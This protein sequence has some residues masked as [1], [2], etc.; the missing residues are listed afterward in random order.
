MAEQESLIQYPT[1]FPIKVVG[2]N[3]EGFEAQIAQVL[4]N[5]A[6]DF[7]VTSIQ[8]RESRAG[9]YLSISATITARSRSQLDALYLE[10]TRH[11]MVRVVL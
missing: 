10:L 7:D 8:V 2:I 3:E 4:R 9:K 5:H 1:E 11:P 6:P